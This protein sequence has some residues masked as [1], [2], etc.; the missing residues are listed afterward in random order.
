[1]LWKTLFW[2]GISD[3]CGMLWVLIIL[4][5][6][7]EGVQLLTCCKSVPVFYCVMF[8]KINISQGYNFGQCPKERHFF[9]CVPNLGWL[10]TNVSHASNAFRK[11]LWRLLFLCLCLCMCFVPS[12]RNFP[13]HLTREH[14]TCSH[15]TLK[16]II[17]TILGYFQQTHACN[18]GSTVYNFKL[19]GV[20]PVDNRPSTDKLHHVVINFFFFFFFFF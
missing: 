16:K 6:T 8:H 18:F 2:M 4:L 17:K 14:L 12:H 19:D 20:G 13:V 1:M 7:R 9:W 10:S 3:H 5:V 15:L 11:N